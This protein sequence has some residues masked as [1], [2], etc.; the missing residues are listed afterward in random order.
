MFC[1]NQPPTIDAFTP[2]K[3]QLHTSEQF[4]QSD[5]KACLL[6][7]HIIKNSFKKIRKNHTNMYLNK[8]IYKHQ[9][10]F[11]RKVIGFSELM[12]LPDQE[13]FLVETSC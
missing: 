4:Y 2:L 13:D 5:S 7:F 9:K 3:D 8:T 6:K 11:S 1:H 12:I 10:P